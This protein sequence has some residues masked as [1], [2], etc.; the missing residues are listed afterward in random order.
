MDKKTLEKIDGFVEENRENIVNDLFELCRIPSV[1]GEPEAGAP[2]GKY[3]KEALLKACEIAE[4]YGIKTEINTERG[5]AEMTLG[6]GE[7]TLAVLGHVD[8]VPAG[9]DWTVTGPFEPVL[10]DGWLYGRGTTDDKNGVITGIYVQRAAKELGLPFRSRLLTIAGCS[11]ETGMEDIENYAKDKKAPDFCMVADANFPACFCEKD[12][13]NFVIGARFPFKDIKEIKG[14]VAFNAVAAKAQA[15]IPASEGMKKAL[16]ALCG[17]CGDLSL[18]EENDALV[19]TAKGITA[20]ASAPKNSKNA[21]YI[22]CDALSGVKELCENDRKILSAAAEA[23]KDPYG[24]GLGIA[25]D[26]TETGKLTSVCGLAATEGGGKFVLTFNIRFAR[27]SSMEKVTAGVTAFC[28]KN[29][30]A[31]IS[32]NVGPGYYNDPNG[33]K[34]SAL[35]DIYREITGKKDSKPYFMGGGTY[36]KHLKN[37]VAFGLNFGSRAP[38][39]PAGHGKEHEPDESYNLDEFLK[40]IKIY[41]AS[42]L[43]M[44][45]IINA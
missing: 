20:H 13:S 14:G 28:D 11:E 6:A 26:D 37:A 32:S 16:S 8:V 39:L 12:I 30:F 35:M 40:G 36:A 38:G 25:A 29:G 3:P 15:F 43:E 7:K 42:A 41:I 31:L 23:I 17:A 19:L 5:Y 44:D 9:E 1:R 27:A 2:F 18:T 45:G 22:L 4:R 34:I 10:K 33:P 24:A 21:V